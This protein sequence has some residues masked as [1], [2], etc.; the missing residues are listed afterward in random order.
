MLSKIM[1]DD[2]MESENEELDTLLKW[3]KSIIV[4]SKS[5]IRNIKPK[6]NIIYSLVLP[7]VI[8]ELERRQEENILVSIR[9]S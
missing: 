1:L 4:I 2:R 3:I 5:R 7:E 6:M 9:H 8:Y